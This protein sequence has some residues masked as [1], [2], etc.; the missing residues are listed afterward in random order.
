MAP[1]PF[2]LMLPLL[3]IKPLAC[4]RVD[5]LLPVRRPGVPGP[6]HHTTP[7][8]VG[9]IKLGEFTKSR[10]RQRQV[11]QRDA[12]DPAEQAAIETLNFDLSTRGH[13]RVLGVPGGIGL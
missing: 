13:Y 11:L 7:I 2:S 3:A 1:G 6:C 8:A 12:G 10:A 9:T 5:A 4:D